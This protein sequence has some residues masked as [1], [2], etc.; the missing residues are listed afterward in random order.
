MK[1]SKFI[2]ALG[3][4]ASSVVASATMA[5]GKDI[6]DTATSAGS[7]NTLVAAIQKAGL[8][9]TLKG[10]GPF[11]VFAPTDAAFAK[12]PQ[13]QLAAILADKAMLPKTLTYHVVAGKFRA[14]DVNARPAPSVTGDSTTPP[15]VTTICR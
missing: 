15:P 12:I 10:D 5:A 9:E 3:I 4:V 11:T 2:A 8:V 13:E 1:V 14:P 6:V 7:F